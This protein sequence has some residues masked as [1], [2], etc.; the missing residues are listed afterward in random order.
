MDKMISRRS[1][2]KCAG[3]TALAVGAG[4]MLSSCGLVDDAMNGMFEQVGAQM[5]HAAA[6]MGS[7]VWA[8]L[9]NM[10][11]RW[12][13]GEELTMLGIEFQVKNKRDAAL[14]FRASDITNV[15]I[16]GHKAQVVVAPDPAKYDLTGYPALFD[17]TTGVKT[18]QGDPSMNEAESG[19]IFFAPTYAEGEA[20]ASKD[21]RNLEFTFTLN[22]ATATF[23]ATRSSDNK[24]T[25]AK[26]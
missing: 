5:G 21:W 11:V 20:H 24:V 17:K 26:K 12:S 1:F 3:V 9:K 10:T 23:T 18:Y 15:K 25:S 14:T 8:G 19:Y 6:T 13:I 2:L 7:N 4:S 16:D 22:G